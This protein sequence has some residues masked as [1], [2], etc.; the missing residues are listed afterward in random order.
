[1]AAAY[2]LA[3]WIAYTEINFARYA[4]GPLCLSSG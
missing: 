3:F 1:M 2:G 4:A